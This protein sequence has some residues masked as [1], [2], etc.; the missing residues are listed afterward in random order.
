[1]SA[2]EISTLTHSDAAQRLN[3]LSH[4]IHAA[5]ATAGR[6]SE[7]VS[8]LAV[9][10]TFPIAAVDAVAA[11]GQRAFGENYAQ[12]GVE[13]A[14]A[15]PELEWHFIGPIQSNK[16]RVIAE[17]FAWV[18]TIDRLKIA[19]RLS[20]QRPT[21]LPPL[22]VCVQVN[23][24]DEASKSGCAPDT[25]LALC[26]A[27]AAQPNLKLRGLMAIPEATDD[28]TAQRHYF[29]ALRQLMAEINAAHPSL[30]LATLSLCMSGDLEAAVAE[31]ATIVRVGSAIFGQRS[32]A[33]NTNNPASTEHEMKITFVGGGNMAS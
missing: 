10:K 29:A 20:A 5:E 14:S 24:S 32:Y 13:K 33:T 17:H 11:A 9:S 27:I 30:K 26:Q 12:E 3:Q 7:S 21:H 15:R 23:I 2:A 6:E 19:E 18:H 4:R 8:L 16:T 1:M 25:A 28:P 31:G 22:Q